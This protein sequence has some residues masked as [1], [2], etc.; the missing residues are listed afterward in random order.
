VRDVIAQ[1][2]ELGVLKMRRSVCHDGR[3]TPGRAWIRG[4]ERASVRASAGSIRR[5][6]AR[7][8]RAW[9]RARVE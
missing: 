7:G 3:R 1:R 8:R 9:G 6:R 5:G 4:E 2:A